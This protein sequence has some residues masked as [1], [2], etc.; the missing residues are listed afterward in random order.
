ML[1]ERSVRELAGV[2]G[3]PVVTSLYLSVDGRRYPRRTDLEQRFTA[4][5]HQARRQAERWGEDVGACV[6]AD[7]AR[8][9]DWL[10][11]FD[12]AATRGVALFSCS[13]NG[14]FEPVTVALDVGDR[15]RVAPEAD[16]APLL[17]L[18]EDRERTL[19]VLADRRTGRLVRV[20]SGVSRELT[21]V[22]D[23]PE[24]QVDTDVE[25]GSWEHRHEEAARRHFRRVAAAVLGEV[26]HWQAT[27][28][29]LSGSDDDLAA[30]RAYLDPA[31]AER[32]TATAAL[33]VTAVLEEVEVVVL[34][35]ARDRARARE[36]QLVAQLQEAAGRGGAALGLAAVLSALAE[37]RVAT[38]VVARGFEATGAR[39]P[40][41]EHVYAAA[42]QCPKCGTPSVQADDIVEVAIDRALAEGATVG[43]CDRSRAG[44]FGGIAALTR[45]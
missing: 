26:R 45:F 27:A 8:M 29:V 33:P 19:V 4:L 22:V 25:L 21:P 3:S 5:C 10:D 14:W 39:C 28:V 38:L 24:R 40:V 1:D 30:L 11:G 41:C 17:A 7:L 32:V 18:L 12:R 44:A 13:A 35:T 20:E 37:R 23:E 16:V 42:C 43:F 6:D 34:G 36:Q 31:V 2:R 9:R 15:V